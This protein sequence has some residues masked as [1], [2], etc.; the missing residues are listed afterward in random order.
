[1]ARNRQYLLAIVSGR[2]S[3]RERWS[4]W[5]EKPTTDIS[6]EQDPTLT[7]KASNM[8]CFAMDQQFVMKPRRM[9]LSFSFRMNIYSLR[10]RLKIL[11][12][13]LSSLLI[14]NNQFSTIDT[15]HERYNCRRKWRGRFVNH[16]CP[17]VFSK[18][19]CKLQTEIPKISNAHLY[20]NW[21]HLCD[22][23][24]STNPKS[25]RSRTRAYPLSL[26]TS[27]TTTMNSSR[28]SPVKT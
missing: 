28:L 18:W 11:I 8:A 27:K 9:L 21:L 16:R 5:H 20:R 7:Y 24:P 25:S 17:L 6:A 4:S 19:V 13:T 10:T 3:D 1:M 14:H 22:L 2:I 15:H 26:S 12:I 23:L